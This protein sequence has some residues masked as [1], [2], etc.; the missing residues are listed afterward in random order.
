MTQ[1]I[2]ASVIQGA[3]ARLSHEIRN[4]LTGISGALDVLRD[5]LPRSPEV[6]E[7]WTRVKREVG[8]IELSLA[9]L[10]AFADA[11][12]PV[13]QTRNLH[14]IIDRVL[15]REVHT[16]TTRVTRRYCRTLPDVTVDEKLLH[17][18]LGRLLRNAFEAMPQGGLLTITTHY[19][20]EHVL[21]SIRDTGAGLAPDALRSVF[22]PFY[23]SKTRGLG[24]GLAIARRHIE[25]H[26]G[27][28]SAA[29]TP[30]GGTEFTV[31]LPIPTRRR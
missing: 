24:L 17:D 5:Q 4:S 1:P 2:P 31:S 16:S 15:N 29:S 27:S 7:V 25:A 3:A 14:Q 30:D 26:G 13:L 20:P 8:R 10:N 21:L 12:P 22:E 11:S 9:E 6:E 28:I 19:T 23:S 18:A